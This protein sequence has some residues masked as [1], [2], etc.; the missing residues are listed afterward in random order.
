MLSV[1]MVLFLYL[2]SIPQCKQIKTR[3]GCV[4][5]QVIGDS[6]DA[7]TPLNSSVAQSAN[8][9]SQDSEDASS[10]LREV[11]GSDAQDAV[12]AIHAISFARDTDRLLGDVKTFSE[13]DVVDIWEV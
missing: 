3:D 4:H 5:S 8:S 12:N 2:A 6:R 11:D 9:K 7:V 10:P 13:A 1:E